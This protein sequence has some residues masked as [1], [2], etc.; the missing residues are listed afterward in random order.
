MSYRLGRS[1]FNLLFRSRMQT[2]DYVQ[3]RPWSGLIFGFV[4]EDVHGGP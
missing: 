3:S 2:P 1:G 4:S